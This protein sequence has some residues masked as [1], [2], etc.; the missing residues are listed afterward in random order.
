MIESLYIL[1]QLEICLSLRWFRSGWTA[2]APVIIQS[3]DVPRNRAVEQFS[4]HNVE[5]GVA[6]T[7]SLP[8][9]D[10]DEKIDRCWWWCST[11]SAQQVL[12]ISP[13][14]SLVQNTRHKYILP[15]LLLVIISDSNSSIGGITHGPF[16]VWFFQNGG[17][18]HGTTEESWYSAKDNL[19]WSH[20]YT[21]AWL[22]LSECKTHVVRGTK[23]GDP[24]I[25]KV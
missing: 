15:L 17:Y 12:I 25:G 8:L 2:G 13:L 20:I 21:F 7:G 16:G 18:G 22:K 14:I 19:S 1:Q 11:Q 3:G 23:N 6:G 9:Q 10:S 4:K 5:Q 24:C